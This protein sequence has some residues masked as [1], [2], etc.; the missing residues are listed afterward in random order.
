MFTGRI[1]FYNVTRDA[2]V[3]FRVILGI[4][5]ERPADATALGL[6]DEVWALM[7]TCWCPQ[8]QKRPR[9]R[10]VLD[11]LRT[12]LQS[13]GMFGTQ[14]QTWPLLGGD[15]AAAGQSIDA[16]DDHIFGPPGQYYEP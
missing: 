5:P 9:I 11:V 8:W 10:P 6:S 16:V 2:T 4:R 3:V 13:Y 1:P 14:P 15:Q 12:N 7:E